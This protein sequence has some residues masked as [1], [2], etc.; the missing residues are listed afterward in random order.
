M[1]HHKEVVPCW[2]TCFIEDV[3]FSECGPTAPSPP[4]SRL[5]PGMFVPQPPESHSSTKS[6]LHS[7][8]N[9]P[10]HPSTWS[11]SGSDAG[12]HTRFSTHGFIRRSLLLC[13]INEP[14]LYFQVSTEVEWRS[15]TQPAFSQ[16][17]VFQESGPQ[18][19]AIKSSFTRIAA[20]RSAVQILRTLHMST[21]RSNAVEPAAHPCIW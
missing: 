2:K 14:H 13:D 4:P 17:S 10:P 3:G 7:S 1:H 19:L 9:S 21:G 16:E 8:R 6:R 5:T 15:S 11:S 18:A 12:F 20:H